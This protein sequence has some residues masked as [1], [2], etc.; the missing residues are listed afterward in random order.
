MLDANYN[1]AVEGLRAVEEYFRF[2]LENAAVSSQIKQLR[3]Q[4]CQACENRIDIWADQRDSAA[5]VGAQIAASDEYDRPDIASVVQANLG[6]VN[7]A[8]RALEEY[9]KA[10]CPQISTKI[11]SIRYRFYDVEKM[12]KRAMSVTKLL[13]DKSIYVLTSGCA[14]STEF[15]ERIQSLCEAGADVIQLRE[16]NLDDRDLLD[17]AKIGARLCSDRPTMFIVNDRPDIALI[18]EADGV[19]VGQ[20]E[21]PVREIRKMIPCRMLVGVS[22]HSLD[23][24]LDAE[25]EGADYIGV[26]PTFPTHTK[27][28]NEFKGPEL[29]KAVHDRIGIPAF[30]IGGINLDN[31]HE[32]AEAGFTRVAVSQ[33]VHHADSAA[34]TI[35]QLRSIL[36][37]KKS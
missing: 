26:G 31:I 7:Q 36:S 37:T 13:N 18:S 27:C 15:A 2:I 5:D 6:R 3:H 12:A 9:S 24:A 30:A 17:R 33:A 1:R 25:A 19:H 4:I 8:L 16:K 32:V 29:L 23:Q 34:E 14:S 10:T 20:E 22:T 28:F 35:H 11:E 21:L